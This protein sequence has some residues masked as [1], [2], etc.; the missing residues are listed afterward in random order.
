MLMKT[1]TVFKGAFND[2]LDLI[3][4]LGDGDQLP[5]EN[6]ISARLGV[7]RTTIRKVLAALDAEGV[8]SGSLRPRC[9]FAYRS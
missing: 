2:A 3:S 4:R 1:D 9:L 8:L 5:S 7:S 6:A